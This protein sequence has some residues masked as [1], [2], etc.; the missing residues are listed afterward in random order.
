MSPESFAI[1]IVA[2]DPELRQMLRRSLLATGF[3]LTEA[4][5]IE[6]AL[7]T[8][9]QRRFDLVLVDAEKKGEEACRALRAQWPSLGIIAVL[10]DEGGACEGCSDAGRQ[11][12][13]MLEAG[14]DDC[15]S[16]P[17]RYREIVARI[18]AVL[19]RP[20]A[21]KSLPGGTRRAGNIVLDLKRRLVRRAGDEIHLS[22]RE[23]DLLAVLMANR[24][25]AL[26]HTRLARTA[27]GEETPHNREYL[28]T[29]IKA[30]RNKLESDPAHPEYI[31]TQPWVGYLFCAPRQNKSN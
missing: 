5:G 8:I 11:E 7:E 21:P 25:I 3:K 31:V 9:R 16:A 27:W 20:P 1:L 24:G 10:A 26:T 2:G 22:P 12:W 29:Y 30:L 19:R 18:S 6:A 17:F 28:R 4:P 14:A 15:I 23:F 13:R